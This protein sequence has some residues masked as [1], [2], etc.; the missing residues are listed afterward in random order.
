MK[1]YFFRILTYTILAASI[2]VLSALYTGTV[3]HNK[4]LKIQVKEQSVIIDS[5][6]KRKTYNFE[7]KLNVTDKSRNNIYGRYNK[8]TIEMPSVKTYMLEIDSTSIN[9]K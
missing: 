4:S 6:L 1:R 8:G 9:F 2:A 5:L 3:K 7:V